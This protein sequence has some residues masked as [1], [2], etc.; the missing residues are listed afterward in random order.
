MNKSQIKKGVGLEFALKNVIRNIYLYKS[1]VMYISEC[2][3]LRLFYKMYSKMQ[4]TLK[5]PI[6]ATKTPVK[7]IKEMN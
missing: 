7:I 1:N 5:I 6:S 2:N 3:K 4:A